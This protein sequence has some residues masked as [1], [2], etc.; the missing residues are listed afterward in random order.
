MGEAKHEGLT[1]PG[2]A[3]LARE[4]GFSLGPVKA[5]PSTRQVIIGGTSHTVEPRVMQV[6]V[7]LA[8]ARGAVVSRDEL[9]DRCWDGRIV[10]DDA[11]NHA[12]AKLRQLAAGSAGAFAIETIPRVGYRLLVEGALAPGDE[13]LEPG[14][15]AKAPLSRRMVLGS[16]IG[17]AIVLAA[18]SFAILPRPRQPAPLAKAYYER[19][20]ATRGQGYA[21]EYEQAVGYFRKAV[22][23]D[24]NYADA[25]GALAWS[26]RVLVATQDRPDS[27]RLAALVNSAAQRAI[28]LDGDNADARLA[29]LLLQ[30]NYRRWAEVERGCRLLLEKQPRHSITQFHLAFILGETGRWRDAIPHMESVCN[31]EPTWPMARARLFEELSNAGRLEEADA[32]LDEAMRVAPRNAYLWSSKIE[33]LLLT[34]RPAE[35]AALLADETARPI[36]ED[37]AVVQQEWIVDAFASGSPDQRKSTVLRLLEDGANLLYAAKVSALLSQRD[38]AFSLLDG[39]Y[40]GRGPWGAKKDL[41]SPTHPLF[42]AAAASLR[43]DP[44]FGRLLEETGLE[45]YWRETKTQPD[46]RRFAEV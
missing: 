14:D 33:H 2:R 38:T 26:Y 43:S 34:E 32:R 3:V 29:L 13:A 9:I 30:P 36:D 37:Q 10:G 35:A 23:I 31:R 18:A 15:T 7:V 45:A 6:L 19:G 22:D 25:W 11:I 4:P 5:S 8:R 17:G 46:F 42:S 39:V 27:A 24:P 1:V 28:S 16:G 44:R 12:I 41:R 21:N 20:L 40:F